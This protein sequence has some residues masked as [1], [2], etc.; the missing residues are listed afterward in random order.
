MGT[1]SAKA[2]GWGAAPL[3]IHRVGAIE[4]PRVVATSSRSQ[5]QGVEPGSDTGSVGSESFSLSSIPV[6]H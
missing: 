4:I 2:K 3:E 5:T 6:V 1:E